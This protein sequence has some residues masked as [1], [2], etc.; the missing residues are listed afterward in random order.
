MEARRAEAPRHVCLS[1][2]TLVLRVVE[3]DL[4]KC[5][6]L[7]SDL[8]LIDTLKQF[9]KGSLPEYPAVGTPPYHD[10]RPLTLHVC[11]WI[12]VSDLRCGN[13]ILVTHQDNPH[14]SGPLH[15]HLTGLPYGF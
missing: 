5:V 10:T 12:P 7:N 4:Q 3:A 2:E 6:N 14:S 9:K 8:S 1:A 13:S 11:E 15:G